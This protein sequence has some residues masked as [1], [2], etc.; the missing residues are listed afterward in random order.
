M[1]TCG[2]YA[3]VCKCPG[4]FAGDGLHCKDV[5]ECATQCQGDNKVRTQ[6][7]VEGEDVN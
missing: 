7:R 5:D 4:G 3:A 1:S 6:G 2:R